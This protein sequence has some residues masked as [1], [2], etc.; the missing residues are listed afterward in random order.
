[1]YKAAIHILWRKLNENCTLKRKILFRKNF[2]YK[3]SSFLHATHYWCYIL[4]IVKLN[5]KRWK[6]WLAVLSQLERYPSCRFYRW[7]NSCCLSLHRRR[8]EEDNF[9]CK[10]ASRPGRFRCEFYWPHFVET[11][12]VGVPSLRR[13]RLQCNCSI[14]LLPLYILWL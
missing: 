9:D 1:M 8:A 5:V 13:L 3:C 12:A 14:L 2:V 6:G 10:L 11:S 4:F 7:C